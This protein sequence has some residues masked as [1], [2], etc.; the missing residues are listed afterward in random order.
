MARKNSPAKKKMSAPSDE[1]MLAEIG[2]RHIH[3]QTARIIALCI[4][5]A[6]IVAATALPAWMVA[7]EET[8]VNVSVALSITLAAT[9][10]GGGAVMWGRHHKRRADRLEQR[11]KTLSRDVKEL[12]QRLATHD[13]SVEVSG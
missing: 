2:V 12:Q 11:N 5:L 13:L 9:L 3:A 8:I 6:L 1:V 4:G 7:G 10:T